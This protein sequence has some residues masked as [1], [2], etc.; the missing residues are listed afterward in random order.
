M[1]AYTDKALKILLRDKRLFVACYNPVKSLP[2]IDFSTGV[3]AKTQSIS[4]TDGALLS[5]SEVK[6]F[7]KDHVITGVNLAYLLLERPRAEID[8]ATRI[9]VH[10]ITYNV[11]KVFDSFYSKWH[12][13]VMERATGEQAFSPEVEGLHMSDRVKCY[14]DWLVNETKI[15]FGGALPADLVLWPIAGMDL[16]QSLK[17]LYPVGTSAVA[18]GDVAFLEIGR[19][20]GYSGTGLVDGIPGHKATEYGQTNYPEVVPLIQE[21]NT[22]MGRL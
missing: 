19:R 9:V 10:G 20:S 1:Y 15:L 21:F 2:S 13:L 7:A 12:L 11:K 16:A 17:Y 3:Q 14:V 22:L 8:L 4:F 6:S 5:S 18:T